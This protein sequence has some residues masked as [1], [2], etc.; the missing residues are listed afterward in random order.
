MNNLDGIKN[1][2]DIA[3][4]F[5]EIIIMFATAYISYAVYK[6][7]KK[8]NNPKIVIEHKLIEEDYT[9]VN[10]DLFYE[11]RDKF[12]QEKRGDGFPC[13]RY[14]D[15]YYN[16]DENDEITRKYKFSCIEIENKGDFPAT[17]LE[18][19]LY[20][21]LKRTTWNFGTDEAD[22]QNI[23][24]PKYKTREIKIQLEY[25]P[26]GKKI[27]KYLFEYEGQF[28]GY[29]VRVGKMKSNE[30]TFIKKDTVIDTVWYEGLEYLSD[31]RDEREV[32]G[33]IRIKE[34]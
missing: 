33:C 15:K 28:I 25:M 10:D 16:A 8:E 30:V 12:E 32:Y 3:S 7:E 2:I 14:Y 6:L 29:D 21:D 34:D 20:I 5:I 9:N 27:R 22:V 11:N 4:T 17:N 26:P 18:I 13:R 1:F 23:Q 19:I 24:T 31:L